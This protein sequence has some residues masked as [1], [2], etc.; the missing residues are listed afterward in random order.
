[1]TAQTTHVRTIGAIH[2]A[3]TANPIGAPDVVLELWEE[4]DGCHVLLNH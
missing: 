3:G 4:W 1:M 2:G